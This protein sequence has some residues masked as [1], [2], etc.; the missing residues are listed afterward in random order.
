MMTF[1]NVRL[2]FDQDMIALKIKY[3]CLALMFF[4]N[5]SVSSQD[6]VKDN[7]EYLIEININAQLI[8]ENQIIHCQKSLTVFYRNLNYQPV[9]NNSALIQAFLNELNKADKEGLEPKDYHIENITSLLRIIKKTT[10]TEAKLDLVLTD[11]FLLYASHLLYGKVNSATLEPQWSLH[12]GENRIISVLEQA[13]QNNNIKNSLENIKPKHAIYLG[14]KKALEQYKTIKQKGGWQIIPA[15]ST[16]KVGDVD[17]RIPLIRAR[18]IATKDFSRSWEINSNKYDH[19]L[20]N[21]LKLFQVR[22]GIDIDG[23]IGFKTMTAMNI[24]VD[25]RIEQIKINLERWRWLSRQ[26]GDYYIKVNIADFNLEVIKN[27][28]KIRQHKIIVGRTYR[29]TPIFSSKI[30][31]LIFNPSWTIPP[32]IFSADVL[33]AVR[34]NIKYLK[35]KNIYVY[36][37]NG[38]I[39]IPSSVDWNSRVVKSYTYRQPPGFDNALGSVKFF[40]PNK[41][42]VYLHDT[43]SK[44]LFEKSERAFSSGCIR[45]QDPIELAEY[46][47]N[48]P[49]N[50]SK[51]R[52][53]VIINTKKTQTVVIKEQP[54]IHIL[55][56]TSFINDDGVVQFRK[57]IYKRDG[58]LKEALLK[59]APSL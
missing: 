56:W 20:V 34:K 37:K 18:L 44:D 31:H 19:D 43:P 40:I 4:I 55:Y 42:M 45:V 26:F 6:S 24:N 57:D 11:A 1:N 39:V 14:L 35:N 10:A 25:E 27:G 22:H 7:I 51:K 3:A 58:A 8:I 54:A 29:K 52:I 32:G 47:L 15:G 13:V 16:I 36:D 48:D 9:W 38:Q 33:P 2:N 50:Y 5:T 53:N 59:P 21:A 30:T 41:F 49:E 12:T 17:P 28:E 46:L 23:E